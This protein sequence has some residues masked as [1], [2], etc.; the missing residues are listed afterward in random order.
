[1]FFNTKAVIFYQEKESF[2]G[3]VNS[4][5]D[6]LF[7]IELYYFLNPYDA[8]GKGCFALGLF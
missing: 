1:M 6:V 7:P 4:Q 2:V 5:T 8:H 3:N